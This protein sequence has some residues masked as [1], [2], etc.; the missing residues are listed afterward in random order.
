VV[1]DAASAAHCPVAA[2]I[3]TNPYATYARIAAL[4]HPAVIAPAGVHPAASVDPSARV[5]ASAS[6]GAGAVIGAHCVLGERVQIGPGSVLGEGVTVGADCRIHSRVTLEHG[7]QLAERVTVRSGAVI[8]ADGFGFARDREGWIPVPQVGSVRIGADADIGA[9]TTIDRGAIDDTVIGEG[10]KLDNQIQV[11]HNVQIGAH[12]VVAGCT[13][14]SGST[15]IGAR[16]MLGGAVGVAGHLDI[17]DDVVVTGQTLVSS[18]I[19]K[20]GVYSGGIPAAPARDWRRMVGRFKRL[21]G[22][23]ARL[24]RLERASGLPAT[25]EHTKDGDDD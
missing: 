12:T 20:P 14:I 21:D 7:V 19:T 25:G 2:L 13:G 23:V 6:V 4:L 8:G 9:N 17:C 24:A 1:L 18:S 3:S 5:A 11:A 16:C 10:V 22:T 15:R